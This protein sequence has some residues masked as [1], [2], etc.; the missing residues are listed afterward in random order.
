MNSCSF[1]VSDTISRDVK[2][3]LENGLTAHASAL[4]IPPYE[5]KEVSIVRRH[6]NGQIVAGL[7]GKV[8][9]NWLYVDTLWVDDALRGQ[10]VGSALMQAAEAEARK[11][12]CAGA[13]VWTESFQGENFYPKL[14]YTE[15]ARM[16]DFPIGHQRIGFMKRLVS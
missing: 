9:W 2:S 10:G 13:Y 3:A 4:D 15:F 11:R 1:E 14:G 12:G 16:D 6:A 8:V 5:E 7:F